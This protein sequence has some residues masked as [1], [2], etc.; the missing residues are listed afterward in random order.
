MDIQRRQP[1]VPSSHRGSALEMP[2][3]RE[4]MLDA[5]DGVPLAWQAWLP[6]GEPSAAVVVIHGGGEHGGRYGEL[7]AALVEHGLAVYAQDLRG[8]GRS[9]GRRGSVRRFGDH[10]TDLD[11]FVGTVRGAHPGAAVFLVGYSLGGLV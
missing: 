6:D 1:P 7:V 2:S 4:G 11:Q 8:H 5:T 3:R 9:G 10:L